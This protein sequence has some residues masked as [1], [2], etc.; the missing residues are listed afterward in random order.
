MYRLGPSKH[1]LVTDIQVNIYWKYVV[2]AELSKLAYFEDYISII[3]LFVI[4]LQKAM[5][6]YTIKA[7][8]LHFIGLYEHKLAMSDGNETIRPCSNNLAY[9]HTA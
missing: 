8:L 3:S 7:V 6:Q 9:V 1:G 5:V 2:E 4:F